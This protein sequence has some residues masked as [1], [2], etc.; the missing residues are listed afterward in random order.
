MLFHLLLT[1][2]AGINAVSPYVILMVQPGQY[3]LC[4]THRGCITC[5]GPQQIVDFRL[6]ETGYKWALYELQFILKYHNSTYKWKF[7]RMKGNIKSYFHLK[8]LSMI[9]IHHPLYILT[10]LSQP[11]YCATSKYQLTRIISNSNLESETL[12]H[13]RLSI[14]SSI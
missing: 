14:D 10:I 8:V 13:G 6:L 7:Q 12:R 11:T 4:Y 9:I 3:T 1:C 5:L 2:P